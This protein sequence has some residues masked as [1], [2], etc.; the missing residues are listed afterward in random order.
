MIKISAQSTVKQLSLLD[1]MLF[2]GPWHWPP[3]NEKN[4]T[5][6]LHRCPQKISNNLVEP[7][8]R[9]YGSKWITDRQTES[10]NLDTIYGGGFFPQMKFATPY[11]L[12][13][14]G[15]NNSFSWTVLMCIFKFPYVP[16]F[17]KHRWQLNVLN[18]LCTVFL[19]RLKSVLLANLI[20]QIPH[21]NCFSN[22][23][24]P[25]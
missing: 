8:L 25:S 4:L 15:D 9:Y 11:L 20:S 22:F 1:K 7:V 12:H 18:S 19:C 3:A 24:Q 2:F 14:Q 16:N 5:I 13:L 21:L 10:Q 17:A 23:L 6:V